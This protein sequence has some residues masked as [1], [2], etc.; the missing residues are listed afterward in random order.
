MSEKKK[1]MIV[2]DSPTVRFEVKLILEKAGFSV[3]QVG[4]EI[5]MFNKIEEYGKCV[6]LIIMDLH[7]KNESGFSLIEKLKA[8]ERYS[9]IPIL[10]LTENI[11][12]ENILKAKTLGVLGFIAKPFH[13]DE[14]LKRVKEVIVF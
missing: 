2:E 11:S 7:L 10:I 13:P 9:L 14:L 1:I 4:G 3:V 6:D 12:K 5:G 8:D